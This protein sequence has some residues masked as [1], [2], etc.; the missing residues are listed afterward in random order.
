[1]QKWE[2]C[3]I[4]YRTFPTPKSLMHEFNTVIG[5]QSH[6]INDTPTMGAT[7]AQLGMQG[8]ELVG[9]GIVA[10]TAHN[11]YFKRPLAE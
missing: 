11:I 10:A 7:I 4:E 5:V 2:Y 3:A 1:M 8:W 6:K 9:C